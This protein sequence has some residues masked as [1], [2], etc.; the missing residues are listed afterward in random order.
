MGRT[1]KYKHKPK[2]SFGL[3]QSELVRLIRLIEDLAEAD[4]S[5]HVAEN[6][7]WVRLRRTVE[8]ATTKAELRRAEDPVDAVLCA[9][10]AHY[11][12]ERPEDVTIYGDFATGYII[13]PTLPLDLRPAP[14][15]LIAEPAKGVR[16]ADS[17]LKDLRVAAASL[18]AAQAA[19]RE[20]VLQVRSEGGSWAMIGNVL[21]VPE[22]EAR[23]RF[24]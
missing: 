15:Q 7:D 21:G 8:I 18:R 6:P 12:T 9:Y 20:A 14:R 3:L 23:G 17:P 5:M 10:I 13:T 4:V 11:A 2:R 24:G 1:L 16:A 19:V 22:H